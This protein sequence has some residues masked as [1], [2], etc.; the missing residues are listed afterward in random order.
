MISTFVSFACL[1]HCKTKN[2]KIA[3]AICVIL[4]SYYFDISNEFGGFTWYGV[5]AMDIQLRLV[6][7]AT[8]S[9]P[10]PS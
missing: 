7:S 4:V 6:M 2:T 3:Y 9:M 8:F 10:L 1:L 5:L